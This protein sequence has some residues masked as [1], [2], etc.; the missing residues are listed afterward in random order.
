VPAEVSVVEPSRWTHHENCPFPPEEKSRWRRK[1]LERPDVQLPKS[2][3]QLPVE[4]LE[5]RC[6]VSC[7]SACQPRRRRA[8]A[9]SVALLSGTMQRGSDHGRA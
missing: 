1:V 2:S 3:G 8:L 9:N 4:A 6:H 5:Q 7:A